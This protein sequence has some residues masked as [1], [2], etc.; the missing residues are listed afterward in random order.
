M[1]LSLHLMVAS[2]RLPPL[3]LAP[4]VMVSWLDFAPVPRGGGT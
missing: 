3:Q 2:T 1:Y 4:V